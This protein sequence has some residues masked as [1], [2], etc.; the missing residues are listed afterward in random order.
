MRLLRSV[1]VESSKSR[2]ICTMLSLIEVS[3]SRR[4]GG[5]K[6][7]CTGGM[8]Y[9]DGHGDFEETVKQYDIVHSLYKTL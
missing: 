6:R 4:E 3:N 7:P 9:M 5:P 1:N 8:S 2:S